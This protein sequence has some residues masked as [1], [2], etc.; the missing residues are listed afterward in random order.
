MTDDAIAKKILR[1]VKQ[2]DGGETDDVV[3]KAAIAHKWMD[4]HGR[5]TPDGRDLV[6]SFDDLSRITSQRH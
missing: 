1:F 5:P 6:S 4:R 3:L 2:L